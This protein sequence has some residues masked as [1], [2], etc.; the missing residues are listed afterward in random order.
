MGLG[1]GPRVLINDMNPKAQAYVFAT[2]VEIDRDQGIDDIKIE[3]II[4][5]LYQRNRFRRDP[6]DLD[7]EKMNRRPNV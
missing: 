6:T 3:N 4:D 5:Y 2:G 7:K 1:P